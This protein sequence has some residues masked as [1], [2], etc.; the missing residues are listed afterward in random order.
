MSSD[1]RVFGRIRT[2]RCG[3]IR[4]I[5]CEAGYVAL[6]KIFTGKSKEKGSRTS[7]LLEAVQLDS[8]CPVSVGLTS[9]DEPHG[10]AF[11]SP[12]SSVTLNRLRGRAEILLK[13]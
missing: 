5:R 8:G 13:F 10:S 3:R 7:M 2:I 9:V 4:T 1:L 6:T 12:E 11:I